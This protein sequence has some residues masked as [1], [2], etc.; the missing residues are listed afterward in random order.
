VTSSIIG[1]ATDAI[2]WNSCYVYVCSC[3]LN[4]FKT[5]EGAADCEIW[6]VIRFLNA[7]NFCPQSS[8]I[9]S[10]G[11]CEMLKKLRRAIQ[12]KRPQFFCFTITL[13]RTLLL[14]LKTSSPHLSG[15]KWTP[16]PVQSW[17]GAKWLSPLPTPKDVP[18]W[19]AIWRQRWPVRCSA[20]VAN[21]AGG[22]FL[23]GGYTKTCAPLRYVP[24]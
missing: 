13:G 2:S 17:F 11:Y 22:C 24:Q 5:I 20:E 4:M 9:N 12:N 16:P 18:G 19:Q 14:N 23:W 1:D 21:I 7:R 8:T 15:N 3:A 6:S 10:D